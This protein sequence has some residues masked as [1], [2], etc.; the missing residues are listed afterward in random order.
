[1]TAPATPLFSVVIPVY[2]RAA[3]LGAALASIRAQ[4]CSDFEVIVVDDGSADDP[5]A[6]VESFA[7]PRMRN[8]RQDNRGAAAARNRGIDLAR[9]R[10]VAFLDSDDL[11]LPD[12]LRT[13]AGL[14]DGTANVVGYAPIVVDRGDGRSMVKPP[15]ALRAGEHMAIYLLCDRGFVPTIT[16]VVPRQIAARVRYDESVSFGDDKDFA[17]RLYLAG[18][19]FVMAGEPGAVWKDEFDPARL[20][21]GRKGAGLMPWIDRMRP[22]I[23][24]RAY[25]GCRGW[26]IA[27]GVAITSK[28]SAFRLFLEAVLR[29]AYRPPMAARIFLQ[30]FLPDRLYRRLADAALKPT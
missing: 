26:A 1:M 6:V 16:L 14:L 29:G 8:V 28:L 15:R 21:A 12:H 27:K 3:V 11:F 19:S 10:F 2:N 5:A 23:P 22:Q 25:Y 20:S 13:M 24:A 18:C 30:I 9:G 17:L 4:S 7:D